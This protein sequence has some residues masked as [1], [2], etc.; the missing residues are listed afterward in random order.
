MG[1]MITKRAFVL[2][3][4]GLLTIFCK[5]SLAEVPKIHGFIEADYGVKISDDKTK[6]DSVNLL[7]QRLQLKTTY[8]FEGENY[9]ADKSGVINFKSDFTVDEYFSG[10]TGFDLREFNLSLTPFDFMD[11]KLGR[12]ILTWG[13]G[14]YLFIN[15]MFPKDYVSFFIGRNDEY[16]KKPSDAIKLSFYPDKINIDFVVIPYFTPNTHAK[17]D[18][19]SFFDSFQGGIAGLTSDR[20][21][22]SP[23]FQ[24]SNNEYALRFYRNLGSNEIAFYYFRGFDKSPRSYKDE[25]A[26][27]LYYERL[28]VYGASIRGPILGGIGNVEAGYVNSREDSNGNNRL[29]ANSMFKA[30]IG[31]SKDFGND[32]KIGFQYYYEQTLKYANYRDNLLSQDYRWDEY[33]HLLTNRI[34]KLLM[35]QTLMLSLFIFYSPSDRDGYVRPSASYDINDQW[36]VTFGANLPWGEDDITEFGQMKKNKNIF[37][38]VRYSF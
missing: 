29:I 33:R 8:F 10:K 12:Q 20:H 30:M 9:L 37:V 31:Y 13:T 35:D 32:L 34:T 4:T 5:N 16:L 18:R 1:K 6:K 38:R 36:K 19:V 7:E 3:L 27:Q 17:G 24:M 2:V 23:S 11:A 21:L 22:I 14:D 25:A 28:D 15:D 26:R